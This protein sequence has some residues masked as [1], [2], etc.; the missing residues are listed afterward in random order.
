[1][2]CRMVTIYALVDPRNDV[3]RY[4]GQTK[5]PKA[6][7]RQHLCKAVNA[8]VGAWLAELAALG[9]EPRFDE[10][11]VVDKSGG[12]QAEY[13]AMYLHRRTLL[14]LGPAGTGRRDGPRNP[15]RQVSYLHFT[16]LCPVTHEMLVEASKS[17]GMSSKAVVAMAVAEWCQKRVDEHAANE[18]ELK[19]QPRVSVKI[20]G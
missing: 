9:L 4:V 12:D 14:N 17:L 10:L 8:R 1:M 18:P 16:H 20:G 5:D 13:D 6:R 7:L 2:K 11:R 3:V 19:F 15:I